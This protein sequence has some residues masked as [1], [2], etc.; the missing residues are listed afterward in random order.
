MQ[1]PHA[2]SGNVHDS[3]P[4]GAN[5]TVSQDT[6]ETP[7]AGEFGFNWPATNGVIRAAAVPSTS[8]CFRPSRSHVRITPLPRT[9][10]GPR[11]CRSKRCE[12]SSRISG[13]T[14]IVPGSA[15]CSIR[16]A[17]FTASPQTS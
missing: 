16:A 6:G 15:V 9:S 5:R 3:G 8:G 13:A 11:S 10:M 1:S 14:W 2:G 17:V 7:D 4:R 12:I